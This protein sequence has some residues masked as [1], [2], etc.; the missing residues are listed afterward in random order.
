MP[1]KKKISKEEYENLDKN[2]LL[3]L[4]VEYEEGDDGMYHYTDDEYT[5]LRNVADHE[6]QKRK[7]IQQKM[8]KLLQ[9]REMALKEK[10][11]AMQQLQDQL[12]TLNGDYKSIQSRYEEKLQKERELSIRRQQ[13]L[14]KREADLE[15]DKIAYELFGD[16]API[17]RSQVE[18]RIRGY[19]DEESDSVKVQILDED[20][21]PSDLTR[22]QLIA[23]FKEN[24][25]LQ[26]FIKASNASGGGS[27]GQGGSAPKSLKDMDVD[28]R[29]ALKRTDPDAYNRLQAGG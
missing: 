27:N 7:E 25:A 12:D 15:V 26:K 4:G 18:K 28:E 3:T 16:D 13:M 23:S 22:E 29:I 11:D 10:E 19:T 5:G 1:L 21:K 2:I 8:Q 20:L 6:K 17:L 9:D 14:E 24:K